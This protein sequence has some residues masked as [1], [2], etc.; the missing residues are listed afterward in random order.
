MKFTTL[1]KGAFL[2]IF[3]FFCFTV[4]SFAQDALNKEFKL[5]WREHPILNNTNFEAEVL[6]PYFEKAAIQEVNGVP[7]PVFIY[8]FPMSK[9]A[10][11]NVRLS[12]EV[13]EN[14]KYLRDESPLSEKIKIETTVLQN[15]N[16]F[17]GSITFIP[18]VKTNGI[19]KRL[20]KFNLTITTK[21][22][23]ISVAKRGPTNTYDSVLK[24]GDIIKIAVSETGMHTISYNFLKEHFDLNI[25]NIDP[26]NIQLYGN[27]G[28]M[29]NQTIGQDRI[30]DLLEHS[31]SI[32]GD[33]DNSFD[34]GDFIL[35]YAQGANVI[36]PNLNKTSLFKQMN[37]FDKKSHYFIKIGN[38]KGK[39]IQE[40]NSIQNTSYSTTS[41]DDVIRIEEDRYNIIHDFG[42]GQGSGN[43]WF[44]EKFEAQR[45]QN[46]NFNI[47]NVIPGK[48]KLNVLF[49]GRSET[50]SRYKVNINNQEFTSPTI[51]GVNT[52][53]VETNHARN[54]NLV[55]EFDISNENFTL[56]F[57]YL[58]NGASST[59]WL[60]FIE[61]NARRNLSMVGQEMMF[62]DLNSI[63]EES[64]T[65]NLAN[66]S[67]NIEVWDVTSIPETSKMSVE[68]TGQNLSFGVE[69]N[70]LKTFIAF[71][72]NST[73]EEAEFVEKVENQ[74]LHSIESADMIVIY[75]KEFITQVER[76]VAHR[77]SQSGLDV[78]YVDVEKIMNEFASGNLDPTALRDYAKMLYDRDPNFKYLLLFGDGSFDPRYIYD[79]IKTKSDFIPVFEVDSLNLIYTYP[80]D[81]YFGLLSDGEGSALIGGM[82]LAIGRI[83]VKSKAEAQLV[84]D[85]IIDYETNASHFGD[86]RNR[87]VF[88]AD[89]E[90][91][92]GHLN[93]ADGIAR[94]VENEHFEF[95]QNKIYLDAYR[96]ISTPGGEKYPDVV[97]EINAAVFKGA[98]IMNYLGH[99]GSK[100]WAQER[101]LSIENIADWNNRTKLP[102]F[103]TAT[104]SFSGFDDPA[105]VTAGE[106]TLLNPK[107]GSIGLMTT[108]RAVFA[109]SNEILTR[110]V[111]EQIFERHESTNDFLPIGEVIRLAKNSVASGNVQENSRK[112]TLLGD[113]S[114]KLAIPF[115]NVH[116]TSINGLT[117]DSVSTIEALQKVT[118]EGEVRDLN[119]NLLND[120][121]GKVFPTVFDK[122][123][124]VSTLANDSGSS[125]VKF[126]S[127]QN[128][129]F[130]GVATVA[131]G[132]FSFTFVVPKDINYNLGNGK[133]SYYATDEIS[134]D[135]GGFFDG[136][137]VGGAAENVVQDDQGPTVEVFMN[138]ESFVFGGT[139]DENPILLV[140]LSDDNGINVAGSSVGHDLTGVLDENTQ[141]SYLLNEFYEAELDDFTK[142]TV[143]FPLF[144][145]ET[146]RHE[147][148][149]KAWD[150][151]N[152]SSEG[153]TEFIV[154]ETGGLAL[155]HV[156]NYPNPFTTNTNFMFE[157]NLDGSLM[158]VQIRIF[159]ISGVLVKTINADNLLSNGNRISDIQ[160]DGLDD[161]GGQL[162]RG[163]YLYKV[164]VSLTESQSDT[165]SAE[166]EFE[167]LVILK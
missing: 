9:N 146:G 14:G 91:T 134:Q 70:T 26:D 68:R 13:F 88:V 45:T 157:H 118:I 93:D 61:I 56:E 161:Y 90:D 160:W 53:L 133:I 107:G 89:D 72:K 139:T 131:A 151:A 43:Q 64:S 57:E 100:G 143:R 103:V 140:K 94:T 156:L 67:A 49:A 128:I 15:R 155:K 5:E 18:L 95:N 84:V 76:F 46:Y 119:G 149:V 92:N 11:L 22:T 39:R 1:H 8:T 104:C 19:Q 37:V 159:T 52:G 153:F 62:R 111:F 78:K 127:Q 113:P 132:K 150:V 137:I 71:D 86:W 148:K 162:A 122:K 98:L 51:P 38:S 69:T 35:F 12:D 32:V 158:N 20:T 112:F 58:E 106:R 74:N 165:E 27:G 110:A 144:D 80:S 126:G 77:K 6:I 164:K 117:T 85:K 142:G 33:E 7:V 136:F 59:G 75:H 123:V 30:D 130:K 3:I 42:L 124:E 31:I 125:V 116:T 48:A 82:D 36:K 101:V 4:N 66:A 83:P 147:I 50:A 97:E 17:I 79:D 141:N 23:P 55:K 121:N 105:F 154:A 87:I 60:D 120:F 2:T 24:D 129:I 63:G 28:G 16:E 41:F 81:D 29:L 163:V 109:G 54:S 166:S 73:F 138:D 21:Q 108:T 99:G 44:G 102:L 10:E 152:N 114:L 115:H 167:K 25:D 135:A 96:Q 34:N 145:L 47:P 40:K 65:F